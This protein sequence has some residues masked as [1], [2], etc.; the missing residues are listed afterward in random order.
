MEKKRR[1]TASLRRGYAE[2]R[3]VDGPSLVQPG[4]FNTGFVRRRT[5]GR[6]YY[7]KKGLLYRKE[8]G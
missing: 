1:E 6:T 2:G 5:T 4:A 3:K 8:K 7:G